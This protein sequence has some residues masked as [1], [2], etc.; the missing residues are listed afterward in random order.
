[1]TVSAQ[2]DP[3]VTLYGVPWETYQRILGALGE[4]QLRHTYDR[5]ALDLRALLYGVDW[6]DYEAFLG[7]IE[8]YPLRHTYRVGTL[9]MMSPRKD[10]EWVRSFLGRLLETMAYELD[11]DIQCIGSTTLTNED[12]RQGLQP[13]EAYY[14]AHEPDVRDRPEY[15]PAVDPPPDLVIEVDVTRSSLPR[16]PSFAALGVPEVW[17]HT[18]Q[19]VHF[20]RLAER[21]EYEEIVNSVSFPFLTAAEVSAVVARLGTTSEHRL[22]KEFIRGLKARG[23]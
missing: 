21:G 18:G 10:H 22:L 16:M 17:R 20:Y 2:S 13:D 19:E 7:A 9:E 11:I 5:G 8:D 23:V 12:V 1:M 15:D 3:Y 4:Y 14:V 6:Q